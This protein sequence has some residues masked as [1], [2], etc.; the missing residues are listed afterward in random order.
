MARGLLTSPQLC[1]PIVVWPNGVQGSAQT[2][3]IFVDRGAQE[4]PNQVFGD[5]PE[6]TNERG[7]RIRITYHLIVPA[8]FTPQKLDLWLID[9][10]KFS[11][12]RPIDSDAGQRTLRVVYV[13][14]DVSRGP[15]LSP[16]AN[17]PFNRRM[18]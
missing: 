2:L 14:P 1:E 3:T 16:N 7:R 17:Q 9:G 10:L 6:P 18:Q 12:I 11:Y 4:G 15:A 13:G 8:S 5:G